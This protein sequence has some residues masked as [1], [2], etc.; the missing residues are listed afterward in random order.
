MNLEDIKNRFSEEVKYVDDSAQIILKGHLVIEDLMTQALEAY[1]L[2]TEFV[3]NARLQFNQK[4]ELCK[5]ISLTDYNNVMWNLIKKINVLRNALSHSLDPERRTKAVES[6]KSIYDQEFEPK[7]RVID[8]MGEECALC[9]A[10]VMGALGYLHSFLAEVKR[11][12]NLIKMIDLG[13]HNG[14]RLE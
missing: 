13:I 6:L 9:L 8:G 10:S 11:L 1:V 2:H 7:T 14:G 4:L 12:E 3:G 5:S